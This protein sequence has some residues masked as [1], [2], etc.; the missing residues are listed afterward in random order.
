MRCHVGPGYSGKVGV[1]SLTAIAKSEGISRRIDTQRDDPLRFVKKS[2]ERRTH[3][4]RI[5]NKAIQKAS[6][7]FE[8]EKREPRFSASRPIQMTTP[9]KG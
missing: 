6:M 7:K 3:E 2:T 4:I 9:E 5:E 8:S 1:M